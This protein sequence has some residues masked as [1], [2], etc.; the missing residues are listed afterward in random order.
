MNALDQANKLLNARRFSEAIGIL[1]SRSEYYEDNFEYYYT[2]G[3]AFLYIGDIGTAMLNLE[4]ARKIRMTDLNLLTAQAAIFMRRGNS[5]R[6]IQ[7]YLEILD[8]DPSNKIAKDALEFLRKDGD[9]ETICRWADDGRIERF[10]PPLGINP[11]N[12]LRIALAVVLGSLF[13]L[14]VVHFIPN[15]DYARGE[16]ADLSGFVLSADD[17]SSIQEKDMATGTFHYILKPR[18]I[19]KAYEASLEYFQNYRDNA[20][21]R[22]INRILG[23]NASPAV[24]Q[25]ARLLMTYFTVPS[26]DSLRDNFDYK[27]VAAD[28][29][30]YM[31]CYADWGG[32]VSN[33]LETE[34]GY[35][36]DLLV[37]YEDMKNVTGIVPVHFDVSPNPP[38]DTEN[39]VRVLGKITVENGRLKLEGVSIYQSI[40]N[41]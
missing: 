25:K 6:A 1:N 8:L 13:G 28:L 11:A 36:F 4:K 22:E 5:E 3:K 19:E 37:G 12:I 41:F 2:L 26:F 14:L 32:R 33:V 40:K 16:R 39:P 35:D 20:S 21:Q 18:E 10:Y 30:L 29:N 7:Y 23:S 9:Y 38:V 17:K 31:D 15:D 24:R 27:E 34:S